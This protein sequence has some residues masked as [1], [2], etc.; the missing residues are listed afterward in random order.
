[1]M[2]QSVVP[3]SAVTLRWWGSQEHNNT[4]GKRESEPTGWKA[5]EKI[6]RKRKHKGKKR[7]DDRVCEEEGISSPIRHPSP[8]SFASD[9]PESIISRIG[10]NFVYC[11]IYWC[12]VSVY[13][14]DC[15]DKVMALFSVPLLH[16]K[17]QDSSISSISCRLLSTP[18]CAYVRARVCV[19]MY[20]CCTVFELIHNEYMSDNHSRTC[21]CMNNDDLGLYTNTI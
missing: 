16:L 1:M 4:Q 10:R 13:V 20:V 5:A 17:G 8:M 14:M 12:T 15:S 18:V 21:E 19:C 11:P 9:L 6:M 2:P 3:H 7:A